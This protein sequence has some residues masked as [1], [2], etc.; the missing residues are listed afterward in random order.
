[1]T[2][3]YDLVAEL[4]AHIWVDL[5]WLSIVIVWADQVHPFETIVRADCLTVTRYR[6]VNS[7]D[8]MES[9]KW[10]NLTTI[11]NNDLSN[12]NVFNLRASFAIAQR[13]L[14]IFKSLKTLRP[15]IYAFEHL[16]LGRLMCL[17]NS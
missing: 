1:M 9:A 10:K 12:D 2:G 7:K 11:S 5:L 14:Q 13:N 8:A 17:C 4:C 16:S 6:S 15:S 3:R